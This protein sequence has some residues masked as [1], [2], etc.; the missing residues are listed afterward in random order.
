MAIYLIMTPIM[1]VMHTTNYSTQP[2][3]SKPLY[4]ALYEESLYQKSF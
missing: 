1:Y 4:H 2:A 3:K